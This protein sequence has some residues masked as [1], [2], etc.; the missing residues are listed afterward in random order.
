MTSLDEFMQALRADVDGF[1][2][3]WREKHKAKPAQWPLEFEDDDTG[4]WWEQFVA[5]MGL[6][7]EE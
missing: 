7:G 6:Q 1:E 5:F 4:A 2:K 3:Y